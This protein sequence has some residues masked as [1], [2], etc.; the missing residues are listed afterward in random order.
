MKKQNHQRGSIFF[1]QRSIRFSRKNWLQL[2]QKPRSK[3][4]ITRATHKLKSKDPNPLQ[5]LE[6]NLPGNVL[7]R[8]YVRSKFSDNLNNS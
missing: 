6:V 4:K 7:M 1:N 5:K 3:Q 8:K 2:L